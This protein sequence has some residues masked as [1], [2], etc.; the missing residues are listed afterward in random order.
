MKKLFTF[1]LTACLL[2]GC[3]QQSENDVPTYASTET[4]SYTVDTEELSWIVDFAANLHN[5]AVVA[6]LNM[7]KQT[8]SM[9]M[10]RMYKK[11]SKNL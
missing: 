2:M 9:G 5:D 1:V 7:Q 8:T 10:M 3:S 6:F 11:Y 4:S